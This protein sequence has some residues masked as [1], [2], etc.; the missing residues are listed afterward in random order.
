MLGANDPV[1]FPCCRT[2]FSVNDAASMLEGDIVY[3]SADVFMDPPG[4]G[5]VE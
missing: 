4:D 5:Q 2:M 1:Y 3:D